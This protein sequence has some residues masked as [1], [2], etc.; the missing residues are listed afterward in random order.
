M[1][2][3][4]RKHYAASRSPIL[5]VLVYAAITVKLAV[6]LVRNALRRRVL[7]RA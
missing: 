1:L 2:R 5:N 3:F 7:A 6:S 4:Y